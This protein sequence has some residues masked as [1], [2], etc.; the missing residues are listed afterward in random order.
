MLH[1]LR[2]ERDRFSI[3]AGLTKGRPLPR[4]F[5]EAPDPRPE[6]EFYLRAFYDLSSCRSVG[7]A[8]GPIPWRDIVH[9]ADWVGLETDVAAAFVVVI[10]AMDSGFLEWQEKEQERLQKQRRARG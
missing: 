2:L 3:E 7:F 4:W 8:I 5:E 9:Y 6:D 10:R 1:D